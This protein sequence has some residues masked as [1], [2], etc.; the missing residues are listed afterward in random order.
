MTST[1]SSPIQV[2]G[3]SKVTARRAPEIGE[4]N[5]QILM[6]LGFDLKAIEGFRASG[7]VPELRRAET[8]SK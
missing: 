1:I 7:A 3:V 2:R 4:H 6:E 8:A 5:E